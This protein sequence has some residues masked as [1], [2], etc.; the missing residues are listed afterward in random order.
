MGCERESKKRATPT[1]AIKEVKSST[2]I[3]AREKKRKTE[4]EVI[5]K[6]GN[7]ESF[8]IVEN[9]GIKLRQGCTGLKYLYT[10]ADQFLNKIEDLKMMIA[11]DEPDLMMITEVIPKAQKNPISDVQ[12]KIDGYKVYKNFKNDEYDLGAS[13][14]R[15]VALYVKNDLQSNEITHEI[16]DE[17]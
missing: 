2:N 6:R 3:N 14:M 7:E 11:G 15:G 9:R 17:H 16:I 13:G 5:R 1:K 10:N 4:V 8:D 12:L